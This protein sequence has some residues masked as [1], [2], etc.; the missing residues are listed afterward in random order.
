MAQ[1]WAVYRFQGIPWFEKVFVS[2]IFSVISKARV[3]LVF[4][5]HRLTLLL[6]YVLFHNFNNNT[7]LYVEYVVF[8]GKKFFV[9]YPNISK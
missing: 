3:S 8:S 2:K 5:Q 9:V 6:F 4:V 1:S 7:G